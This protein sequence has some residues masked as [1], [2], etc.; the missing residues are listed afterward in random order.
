VLHVYNWSDYIGQDTIRQFQAETGIRVV[1]DVY[2]NNEVLEAKLLAGKSGYDLVFPTDRPF[3]QRHIAAG[4]Y[5]KL[6]RERLTNY[7]NLDPAIL[8]SL[9]GA[10]P[11]NAHLVPYMWGATGIGYNVKKVQEA[12]GD[13]VALDSWRLLFDP[14]LVSKL[15][16][17]GVSLLDDEVETL[18]AALIYLGKN[19][20]STDPADLA[21]AAA[22]VARVRPHLRYFHSS[23]Y[24][25][26][27]ANGDTCV[28]H[29]YSGDVMQAR[30]RAE[31]AANGVEIAFSIPREGAMMAV[32]VMAVPA[33]APHPQ[34]AH[35]F[36]DYLLRP[37][38]IAAVTNY[39]SFANANRAATDLVDESVRNDPGI[40]PPEAT[41]ARLVSPQLLPGDA[42][43]QRVRTWT[44]VKTGQ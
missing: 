32:D 36:I 1:Y 22:A 26:D 12:L 3:A 34:N 30:D 15:A 7:G 37:P 40:Y 38:V 29:G 13:S 31:E 10:D 43:R 41:R 33:D 23:Q 21:A 24:I 17:C 11:G 27:L 18:G 28:A 9:Q 16:A 35:R 5:R 44:R 20:N 8:Q 39:V 2:D 14:A 42:Q 4:L 19:P 25:N 6:D